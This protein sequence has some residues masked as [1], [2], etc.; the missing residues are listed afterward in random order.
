[1]LVSHEEPENLNLQQPKG[2]QECKNS[3]FQNCSRK[4]LAAG[5]AP[6][7]S[8]HARVHPAAVIIQGIN[9]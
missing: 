8:R 7:D 3:S 2:R 5:E 4:R 6:V 9:N 1:M